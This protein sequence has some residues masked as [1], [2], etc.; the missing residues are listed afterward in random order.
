MQEESNPKK[1]RYD[2]LS[3][4][5]L[6]KSLLYSQLFLLMLAFI[7]SRIFFSEWF[8]VFSVLHWD[9]Y[10]ILVYGGGSAF[11]IVGIQI[12]LSKCVPRYWMGDDGLNERLFQNKGMIEIF[13]WVVCIAVIEEFLFRGVIQTQFGFWT[14]VCIFSIVHVRYLKKWL[15]LLILIGVS[16]LLGGVFEI[17]ENLATTIF[18]HFIVDFFLILYAKK[19]SYAREG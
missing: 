14:A 16:I 12:A 2:G 4:H 9:F 13:C 18:S 3:E 6:N 17:T 7:F 5:D 1:N 10:E 11:L 8:F 15:L 19:E